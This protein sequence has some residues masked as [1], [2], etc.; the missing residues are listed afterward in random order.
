M[1]TMRIYVTNAITKR[2]IANKRLKIKV[3]MITCLVY[4]YRVHYN[5][6]SVAPAH[7]GHILHS[8]PENKNKFNNMARTMSFVLTRLKNGKIKRNNFLAT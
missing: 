5:Q 2:N 1:P 7:S 6:V 8:S 3:M 4:T